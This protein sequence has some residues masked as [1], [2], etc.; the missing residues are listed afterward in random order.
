MQKRIKQKRYDLSEVNELKFAMF[1]VNSKLEQTVKEGIIKYNG[2]LLSVIPATGI[3]H[4]TM[5]E[6]VSG[7]TPSVVFLVAVRS[8]DAERLIEKISID[9]ELESDGNGKAFLIDIDGYTG[10]KALFV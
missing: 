8:E 9:A 3:S 1:I 2:R 4:L 7:G 10:A 5:F 6:A